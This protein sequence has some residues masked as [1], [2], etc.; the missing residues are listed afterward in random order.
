MS[1]KRPHLVDCETGLPPP[2]PLILIDV[3]E[4]APDLKRGKENLF[5]ENAD[6]AARIDGLPPALLGLSS[7]TTWSAEV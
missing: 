6:E 1:Y 3:T 4:L 2:F 5:H 7:G